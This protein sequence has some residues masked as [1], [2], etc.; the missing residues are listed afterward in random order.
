MMHNK[1]RGQ[2][3]VVMLLYHGSNVAVEKPSVMMTNRGLDFGAGFY[4]S[5]REQQALHTTGH[6]YI[7]D[8][9]DEYI[10]TQNNA[11]QAHVA[12][13]SSRAGSMER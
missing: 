4:T 9:I 11:R 13:S 2:E 3:V 12:C 6:L 8:S 5:S 7:V 10:K 1:K